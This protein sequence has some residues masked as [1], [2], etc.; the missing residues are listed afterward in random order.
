LIS[1]K[2]SPWNSGLPNRLEFSRNTL[3]ESPLWLRQTMVIVIISSLTKANTW[4]LRTSRLVNLS[5]L[6]GSVLSCPL[7]KRFSCSPAMVHLLPRPSLCQ[8]SINVISARTDSCISKCP[9]KTR[10]DKCF[11]KTITHIYTTRDV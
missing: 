3:T 6:Y 2:S 9:R 11:L 7:K 10:L 4:C 1:R 8:A 5:M